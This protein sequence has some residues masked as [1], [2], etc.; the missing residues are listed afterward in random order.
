[1]KYSFSTSIN[2]PM[3]PPVVTELV[4][5]PWLFFN[6]TGHV[7]VL[8]KITDEKWDICFNPHV[9]QSKGVTFY[10]VLD[11][12]TKKGGDIIYAGSS[13]A[14]EIK[15]AL[16]ASFKTIA[17]GTSLEISW[18]VETNYPFFDKFKGENFS[19]TP[20]HIIKR[21]LVDRIPELL[22]IVGY[23]EQGREFL[24]ET[25]NLSG[26]QAIPYVK[27]KARDIK[28][29]IVIGTSKTMKFTIIVA[30]E[31]FDNINAE[32]GNTQTF[33]GEAILEILNNT[34]IFFIGIYD[35]SASNQVRELA[36]KQ[37]EKTL[38]I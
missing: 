7:T 15:M 31:Q 29:C 9:D 19:L 36:E 22:N 10:G 18:D 16:K 25:A 17:T 37:Y 8:K 26:A 20:E 30:N 21:H 27:G 38:A 33:G 11:G 14:D 6:P 3:P 28:N 12:P 32:S 1:M 24:L 23:K 35:V 2:F 5:N 13:A 34:E 4:S